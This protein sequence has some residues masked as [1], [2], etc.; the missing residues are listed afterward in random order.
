MATDVD[1]GQTQ[2]SSTTKEVKIDQKESPGFW[3]TLVNQFKPTDQQQQSTE[4]NS[5]STLKP[6]DLLTGSKT[7]FEITTTLADAMKFTKSPTIDLS[8]LYVW[9][10]RIHQAS[11]IS[12]LIYNFPHIIAKVLEKTPI[13]LDIPLEDWEYNIR[14]VRDS[15][16]NNPNIERAHHKYKFSYLF[17]SRYF[18]N[19]DLR[20]FYDTRHASQTIIGRHTVTTENL[21]MIML[22]YYNPTSKIN[23]EPTLF[24]AFKGSMVLRDWTHNFNLT[25]QKISNVFNVDGQVHGGFLNLYRDVA[26]YIANIFTYEWPVKPKKIIFTGHSAGGALCTI[27]GFHAAALKNEM[28]EQNTQIQIISFAAPPIFDRTATIVFNLLLINGVM[29]FDRVANGDT[30]P[31]PNFPIWLRHP[32][33]SSEPQAISWFSHINNLYKYYGHIKRI[34]DKFGGNLL[35]DYIHLFQHDNNDNITQ[36]VNPSE[37]KDEQKNRKQKYRRSLQKKHSILSQIKQY[38]IP[39]ES[40]IDQIE[41]N[42]L[43]ARFLPN[44]VHFSCLSGPLCHL[45]FMGIRTKTLFKGYEFV[46]DK[47][48]TERTPVKN[49][50]QTYK[51]HTKLRE[52][53][54]NARPRELN[55]DTLLYKTSYNNMIFA[56]PVFQSKTTRK[57][58]YFID[59]VDD[60]DIDH[61][62]KVEIQMESLNRPIEEKI[63]KFYKKM[64]PQKLRL[65]TRKV[66]SRGG[67]RSDNVSNEKNKTQKR[68]HS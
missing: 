1:N 28:R 57:K 12:Q 11:R 55:V 47:F 63:Y 3:D 4:N 25:E 61:D 68:I 32:G 27:A 40:A 59:R 48:M 16:K 8:S 56:I 17:D 45:Y 39:D 2:L 41:Q 50:Q 5:Q 9:E 42:V 49:K 60:N 51:L 15:L 54:K 24:V 22:Y 46:N 20:K 65:K 6:R 35:D 31:V 26:D 66:A 38:V 19:D 37:L 36:N 13:Y 30:D 10:A 14:L 23:N 67:V 18:E 58:R 53:D 44:K 21:A 43:T 52:S 7:N 29:K 62:G 34:Q 64:V 33:F